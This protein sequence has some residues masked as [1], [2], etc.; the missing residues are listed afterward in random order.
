MGFNLPEEGVVQ[1]DVELALNL[2]VELE[3]IT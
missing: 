1:D 2:C 3:E